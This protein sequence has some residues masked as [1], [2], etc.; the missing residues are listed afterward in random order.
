M[1]FKTTVMASVVLMALACHQNSSTDGA[2]TDPGM[3]NQR[4][5]TITDEPS[6]GQAPTGTDNA[7]PVDTAPAVAGSCQTVDG[8]GVVTSCTDYPQ[9]VFSADVA[10]TSCAQTNPNNRFTAGQAC[11][12]ARASGGC[13]AADSKTTTW[14]YLAPNESPGSRPAPSCDD[15]QLA[16]PP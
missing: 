5:P 7:V 3:L 15:G 14:F 11:T 9:P 10:Q 1:N 6:K 8:Q 2:T 16:T 12:H 13:V 4:L